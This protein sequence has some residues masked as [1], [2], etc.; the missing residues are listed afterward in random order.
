MRIIFLSW[1]AAYGGGEK[2]LV[3]LIERL[4]LSQVQPVIL[5]FGIDPYSRVL[6]DRL[7]LG[8]DVATGLVRNSF[9]RTWSDFRKKKPDRVVFVTGV[10]GAF[11]WYTFLAAR[12]S[13]AK[14]VYAI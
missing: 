10:V 6:N 14:R 9:F 1:T 13:G 7:G 12:L 2:H 8:I 4:D 5:C 3:D 11:P